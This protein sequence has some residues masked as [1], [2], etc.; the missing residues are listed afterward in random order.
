MRKLSG[1][2]VQ[3]LCVMARGLPFHFKKLMLYTSAIEWLN[4]E[5]KKIILVYPL[6]YSGLSGNAGLEKGLD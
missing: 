2:G 3:K 1:S 4:R 5:G 6:N